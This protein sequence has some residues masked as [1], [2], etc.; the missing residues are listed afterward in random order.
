MNQIYIQKKKKLKK[1]YFHSRKFYASS[2]FF[3]ALKHKGKPLYKYARR[4]EYIKKDPRKI[5][6]HSIENIDINNNICKFSISCS[7]GT[8]IR[9]IARDLGKKLNCGGHMISLNRTKTTEFRISNAKDI[10]DAT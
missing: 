7:K 8:Y 1:S 6:V 4:G 9:S 3:S 2:S 10:Q 5:T